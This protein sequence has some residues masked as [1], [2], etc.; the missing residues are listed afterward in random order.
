MQEQNCVIKMLHCKKKNLLQKTNQQGRDQCN[1]EKE[2]AL[3]RSA[4]R[5]FKHLSRRIAGERL[6]LHKTVVSPSFVSGAVPR[7]L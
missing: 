1:K 7:R 6:L 3:K 4:D 5:E 2:S